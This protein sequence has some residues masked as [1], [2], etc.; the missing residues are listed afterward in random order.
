MTK[1]KKIAKEN[2]FTTLF[3]PFPHKGHNQA[4]YFR[5]VP[6]VPNDFGESEDNLTDEIVSLL[7]S[8]SV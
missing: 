2:R 5:P 7:A 8:M 4:S 1:T 6:H 3:F